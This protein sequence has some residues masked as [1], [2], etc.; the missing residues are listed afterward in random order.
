[1][2]LLKVK[3]APF[4]IFFRQV[5][6][7]HWIALKI[8]Y[9]FL[10]FSIGFNVILFLFL[11][12][13]PCLVFFFSYTLSIFFKHKM[14][15]KG[16]LKWK[17]HIQNAIFL[18]GW[19]VFIQFIMSAHSFY[20]NISLPQIWKYFFE[21][22]YISTTI[23]ITWIG[24]WASFHI[25]LTGKFKQSILM[26]Y[27][28]FIQTPFLHISSFIIQLSL[29]I[30]LFRFSFLWIILFIIG[31][32]YEFILLWTRYLF[33]FHKY[34]YRIYRQNPLPSFFVKYYE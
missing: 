15:I 17:K 8:V 34:S 5:F 18:I 23:L 13:F 21:Y 4:F 22:F 27:Y 30:T 28:F 12:N 25:A 3:R 33:F 14:Q 20:E 11:L 9:D 29:F 2:G 24:I 10:L 31:I 26:S 16:T 7:T 1:M 19:G 32:S 6:L